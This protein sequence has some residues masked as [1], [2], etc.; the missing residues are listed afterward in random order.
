M[1]AN[2]N[3]QKATIRLSREAN[4]KYLNQAFD[5]CLFNLL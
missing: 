4:G 2:G 1:L 3:G 5:E